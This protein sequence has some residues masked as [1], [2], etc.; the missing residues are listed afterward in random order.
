MVIDEIRGRQEDPANAVH[1]RAWGRFFG[2]PLGHPICGTIASVRRHDGRGDPPLR[3]APLRARQHG[4]L[5]RGRRVARARPARAATERSR[6]AAPV[7][8]RGRDCPATAPRPPC[9]S[10]AT[11]LTQSYLVR[12]AAAPPDPRSVLALSLAIEIVGADPDA[13]LFQEVRERLGLGY[14]VGASRRARHATGPSR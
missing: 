12:I 6:R 14:D 8:R 7:P 11:N 3:R 2:G 9:V 13:R 10:A 4:R 1:E 5:A